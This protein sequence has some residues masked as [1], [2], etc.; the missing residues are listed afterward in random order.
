MIP[1]RERISEKDKRRNKIVIRIF[2]IIIIIIILLLLLRR[3]GFNNNDQQGDISDDTPI[4]DDNEDKIN[5]P[6]IYKDNGITYTQNPNINTVLAVGT[7]GDEAKYLLLV[8]VDKKNEILIPIHISRR[9]ICDYYTLDELGRVT[10][11]QK[12]RIEKSFGNGTRDIVSLNNVKDAVQNLFCNMRIDYCM[13]MDLNNVSQF[14]SDIG[15]TTF[16]ITNDYKN[17]SAG[18]SFKSGDNVKIT[19]N[20]ALP[21]IKG[22]EIN[23]NYGNIERRQNRYINSLFYYGQDNFLKD[24]QY[25]YK[26]FADSLKYVIM[27]S[28]GLVDLMSEVGGYPKDDLVHVSSANDSEDYYPGDSYIKSICF[29]YIYNE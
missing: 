26:K 17:T 9:T 20:N 21:L 3:C 22:D 11:T 16:K 23:E 2:L 12:G 15:S 10:G 5:I 28:N 18:L 4:V 13:M 7:D 27:S 29:E 1:R 25:F 14:V 19:S 24:N 6:G 8:I